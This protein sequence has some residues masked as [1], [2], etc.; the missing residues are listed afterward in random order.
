MPEYREHGLYIV[1]DDYFKRFPNKEWTDNK[2]EKRPY[3]Y[4]FVDRKGIFWF[5]PLTTQVE[6][7]KAKIKRDEDKRG[8]GTCIYY[9]VGKIAGQERGFKIGDMF[10]V[11][12]RYIE[13]NFEVQNIPYFVQDKNLID[14]IDK[15]AKKYLNLVERGVIHNARDI[16]STKHML[17]CD[18]KPE[19]S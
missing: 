6:S 8:V 11:T 9:H 13:R 3:Y 2:G 1:K 16:I 5:I 10:P 18:K 7:V 17:L 15:K 12:E 4:A 19:K 14:A